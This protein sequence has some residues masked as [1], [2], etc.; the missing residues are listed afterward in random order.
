M[1]RRSTDRKDQAFIHTE[2]HIQ[3]TYMS[4]ILF[5]PKWNPKKLEKG[6]SHRGSA[7]NEPD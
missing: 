7:V 5:D 3:V 6:S 4:I 1:N 2:I